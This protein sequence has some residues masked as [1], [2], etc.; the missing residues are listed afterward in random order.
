MKLY[1]NFCEEEKEHNPTM[2]S[3]YENGY[4]CGCGRIQELPKVELKARGKQNVK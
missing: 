4:V 1:C 3:N 2:D